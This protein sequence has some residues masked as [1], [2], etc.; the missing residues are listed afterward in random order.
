MNTQPNS[1]NATPV[2][3]TSPYARFNQV[4]AEMEVVGKEME[5]GGYDSLSSAP[6]EMRNRYQVLRQEWREIFDTF[7]DSLE[8]NEVYRKITEEKNAE[9]S[10]QKVVMESLFM[11]TEGYLDR[12][13]PELVEEA[14]RKH[15]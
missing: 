9:V 10:L 1:P 2:P 8:N 6:E 13:T 15:P 14:Y 7:M 12:V 5:A 3:K 11:M 4:K